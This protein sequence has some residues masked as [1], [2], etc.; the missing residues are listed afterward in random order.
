MLIGHLYVL[1]EKCLFTSFIYFLNWDIC[2]LTVV[3]GVF[4]PFFFF[5]L[6][7]SG[8]KS[9]MS[10]VICKYFL[11]FGGLSFHFI[12]GVLGAHKFTFNVSV[13][14]CLFLVLLSYLKKI[15]ILTL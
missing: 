5:F 4:F 3:R 6:I 11:P 8:Y 10:Y 12:E 7:C 14:F 1:F 2:L 9:L 13:F 15:P